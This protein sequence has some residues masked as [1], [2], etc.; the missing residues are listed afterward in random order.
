MP[1]RLKE[2]NQL[3]VSVASNGKKLLCVIRSLTVCLVPREEPSQQF[4]MPRR[5]AEKVSDLTSI[6]TT[7]YLRNDFLTHWHSFDSARLAGVP[8]AA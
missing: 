4:S 8:A 5:Y 1:L 3:S 2:G 7:L 6:I